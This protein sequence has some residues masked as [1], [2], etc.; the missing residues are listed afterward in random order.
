VSPQQVDIT[1]KVQGG[2]PQGGGSLCT[3]C[4]HVTRIRGVNNQSLVHCGVL[5]DKPITFEVAECNRYMNANQPA[6]YEMEEIAWRIV[7]KGAGRVV[8]FVNPSEFRKMEE[9]GTV[10]GLPK[11]GF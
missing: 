4:R 1:I 6:L 10:P 2:T 9:H 3:T 11:T 5:Q 7:T 8:G